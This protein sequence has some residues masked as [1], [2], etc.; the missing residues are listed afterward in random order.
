M[1]WCRQNGV[2]IPEDFAIV[3]FDDIEAARYA[4]PTLSSVQYDYARVSHLAIERLMTLIEAENLPLPA[5][6]EVVEPEII[7]R[8]SCGFTF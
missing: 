6:R 5:K 3:G 8:K 7:V 4:H 1:S 2:K